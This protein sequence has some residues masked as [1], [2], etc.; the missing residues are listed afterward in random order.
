MNELEERARELG[1]GW[2]KEGD[3][4]TLYSGDLVCFVGN[5][6][7]VNRLTKDLSKTNRTP[8]V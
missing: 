4:I 1:Y 6:E 3:T 2:K 8:L 7:S 5:A